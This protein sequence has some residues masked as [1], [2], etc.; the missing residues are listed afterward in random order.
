MRLFQFPKRLPRKMSHILYTAKQPTWLA[1][2]VSM[3]DT[4]L[5]AVMCRRLG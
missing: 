2:S 4:Y 3:F 5:P 1:L